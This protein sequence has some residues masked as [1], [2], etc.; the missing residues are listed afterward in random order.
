MRGKKGDCKSEEIG[1]GQAC[2]AERTEFTLALWVGELG[3][4][5]LLK[6]VE[7][8]VRWRTEGEGQETEGEVHKW[9][10]LYY[11]FSLTFY[12]CPTGSGVGGMN[13]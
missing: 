3:K 8:P 9:S 12:S 1:E 6:V 11:S 2:W 4:G 5:R 13:F 10:F 7:K